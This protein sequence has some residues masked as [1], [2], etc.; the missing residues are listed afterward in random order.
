M[1]GSNIFP[2]PHLTAELRELLVAARAEALDQLLRWLRWFA[3]AA[4]LGTALTAQFAGASWTAVALYAGLCAVLFGLAQARRWPLTW[5]GGLFVAVVYLT[6]LISLITTGIGGASRLFLLT[7]SVL[8]TILFGTRGGLYAAGLSLLTWFGLGA[9]FAWGWLP[10]PNAPQSTLVVDWLSA[11]TS[12]VLLLVALVL[13]QRQFLET[14]AFALATS[15]QKAELEKTQAE[16]NRQRDELIETS[17]QLTEANFRLRSQAQT[18]ERRAAQWAI[19]AEVAQTAATLRDLDTLLSDTVRL[20]SDRFGFYHAGIFLLDDSGEWAVLRAANSPGGQRMLA[21]GHRL[22]VGQQGIV[23]HVTATGLPRI[24]LNVGE[25]SVHFRNPDLPET[26]SEM[27]LPMRGRAGIIGALDV[28]SAQVNAFS[29]DDVSALQTLADQLAVAIDNARLFEDTQRNLA[30]LRAL[31][32]E[33]R[34]LSPVFEASG[35]QAYRYDGVDTKSIPTQAEPA[36]P[37]AL[38][39]PIRLGE[40][41]L[42]YIEL[43]RPSGDWSD[44]DQQL[45]EA[46]A[47]RMGFAL[48][49][50]RLFAETRTNALRMATL[51]EVTLDLTGPQ[52]SFSGLRETIVQRAVRLLEAEGGGL[53]LPTGAESLELTTAINLGPGNPIGLR[54]KRGHGPI[55]QAL[56]TATPQRQ[57][58][59]ADAHALLAVPLNWQNEVLGVL[60]LRAPAGRTFSHEDETSARLFATAAASALQNARLLQITRERVQELETINRVSEVLRSQA[61]LETMLNQIGQQVL[62]TFGVQ[63]GYI[64]LYDSASDIIEFPFFLENGLPAP[65]APVPLGQGLSS[66]VIRSRQPLL[67]NENPIQRMQELGAIIVGEPALS[68]LSVPI[69]LGDDVIGILNVQSTAQEGLFGEN[70][71]RL[72]SIIAGSMGAAIQNAR[73][74]AETRQRLAELE[75]INQIGAVLSSQADLYTMLKQVGDKVLDI[76]KVRTGYIGLYEAK[77]NLIEFPYFLEDGAPAPTPPIPLG[78]GP[79]SH[80]L[81]TRQPLLINQNTAARMEELGATVRGNPALSY[82][83]VPIVVGEDATGVICVQSTTREG[84]FTA[85]DVRLMSIIAASMGV[86]IENARLFQQ[87]QNALSE[88]ESLYQASAELNTAQNYQD[89]ITAL[90]RHTLFR[91]AHAVLLHYFDTP[92]TPRHM[93]QWS[94]TLAAWSLG[95]TDHI[96]PRAPLAAWMS[97]LLRA[98][99]ATAV[100]DIASDP[101]FDETA[102][103]VFMIRFSAQSTIFVPL[104]IG[105]DWMGYFNAIFTEFTAFPEAQVRQTMNLARQAAVLVENFR[106]I[107]LTERRAEQLAAL[108]RV[109]QAASSGLELDTSLTAIAREMVQTFQAASASVALLAPARTELRVAAEYGQRPDLPAGVGEAWQVDDNP[110]LQKVLETRAPLVIAKAQAS[111]LTAG[112]HERLSRRRAHGLMLLPLMVRGEVIGAID[113]ETDQAERVFSEAEVELAETMAAQVSNAIENSRL[114]EQVQHR[115]QQLLTAAEVSRVAVSLRNTDEL[116]TQSVELIRER[117]NLYYAALFLSDPERQWAVLVHATGEAGRELLEQGHKLEIGGQSMIGWAIAHRQAR[118]ALDVGAERVRFANPL[119]PLTRSEMALPLTVGDTVLGALSVQS[120]AA[121]AFS[122]SDVAVLQTMADQIAIAISNAQLLSE[123][124]L[125]LQALDYERFLLQTLLD[126]VPDKIYF[127]DKYSRFIRASKANADSFG[128]PVEQ[129]IGKTDFDFFSEAHAR[130]AYEDE[131]ELMRS[132]QAILNHLERETWTDRPDSWVLTSRLVLRDKDGNPIGTFGIS[133]DVT[134]LK[135]AQEDAQ[136]RAQQLLAV[137]DVSRAATSLLNEGE[138]I[139]QTVE[140]IRE[141][142]DLYYVALFLVEGEYAVLRHAT[143]EAGRLLLQLGHQLEIGGKSMVGW[144]IAN[145]KAR[146][147]DDVA[148]EKVRFVNPLT[149]E[150]RSEI[151][152][153]LVVGEAVLGAISVQSAQPHAFSESDLAILQVMADQMAASL[154]NARL[155]QVVRT[156]ERNASALARITQNVAGQL[157]ERELLHTLASDLLST[158]RADGVALYRWEEA[159]GQFT[160]VIVQVDPRSQSEHA[161]PAA[162]ESIPAAQRPDLMEVLHGLTHKARPLAEAGETEVRESLVAPLSFGG[163][164]DLV[165]EMIH[166]GPRPGLNDDDLTLFRAALTASGSALQIARLYALQRETAERLAEVDRLKSQFLANMSHELRTPLNSIIGFSRV[167]LKGIDGPINDLQQQDLT[168]IYNSGQHLLG[169]INDILDVSRIEAGKMELTF[170]EVHL[171]E[172]IDGVLSTTRGLVKDRNIQLVKNV[173]ADLPSVRADGTRVRQVLLNLLSNAAKFTEKGSITLTAQAA[174]EAGVRV[175][176]LSVSDTGQGI[177]PRDQA[178]LFERFSQVDGSATRK[179]GGTGLGLNITRHL[180]EMHG[181]RIWLESEGIPGHGATFHFTLPVFAARAPEPADT[182]ERPPLIMVVD[183]DQG[184]LTLYRRYLE[185]HGYALMTVANSEEALVNAQEVRPAAILL[186][187]LMPHR[188]G[189]QVLADLKSH[190]ATRDI[191]VIMCTITNERERALQMG[192]AD[193]LVKPILETDLT[194]ALSRLAVV[195]KA[196]PNGAHAHV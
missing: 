143:G 135:R 73:L 56:A 181:G 110:A 191:P 41:T 180:V 83:G 55:G 111:P 23:G 140:L 59:A 93:P 40:D 145:R 150:T 147:A 97:Q 60:A 100:E 86:A 3:L 99:S 192:A 148:E 47:E 102:R 53:W 142:F 85:N 176:A 69:L 178:R 27:A 1:K 46:I 13:P 154:Q 94:E 7:F 120:T 156:Q 164:A 122:E 105:G 98:G 177:A 114:Y 103:A 79:T 48:E 72:L 18:L 35:A 190:P 64:A 115:A 119:L 149:P 101:R 88:T 37:G 126:N 8:V 92:W 34:Q 188:D 155:Y 77:T 185:P 57:A 68:Y 80:I 75:V 186:D 166:T 74:F 61:D 134:E 160:P 141:R 21:R 138:L 67:I 179:V 167:I 44:E 63:S 194:R 70:D 133:R 153:P 183:D 172:I 169:L 25:D 30:E 112:L 193:Y 52:F 12:F 38:Q 151:A 45:T 125:T 95:P 17:R 123:M 189:W 22:Q 124:R 26:Q 174:V 106:N 19:S 9:A 24:A 5:R 129:I 71:V 121:N 137:A 58:P 84:L 171:S 78:R 6:G 162:D 29:D 54:V 31:Q 127:K 158:Y 2:R 107:A 128:L 51:S 32:R 152:L 130:Q 136:R 131:Q 16:L 187:V 66:H 159:A 91:T 65:T 4:L 81:Q 163:E 117:F 82:L 87:T 161:W 36:G 28:Q 76:F 170:D 11:G 49:N 39:V 116:I 168:S 175:V 118:I 90:R 196:R 104:V 146:L 62:E 15:Q 195:P 50:A 165:V 157:D 10:P 14:Q 96:A 132:G 108:N 182:N 139:R 109:T 43:Q 89:L 42:G 20:I 113:V 144:A 33:A 184:L 173:P